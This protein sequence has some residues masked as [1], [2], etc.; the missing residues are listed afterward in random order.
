MFRTLAINDRHT[1]CIRCNYQGCVWSIEKY[2]AAFGHWVWLFEFYS[3]RHAWKLN[4]IRVYRH[5]VWCLT[6]LDYSKISDI[7]VN[8]VNIR[9]YPDFCDAFIASA[10]YDGRPMSDSELD[11]LNSDTDYVYNCVMDRLYSLGW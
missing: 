9:N 2:G 3:R 7:E 11:R 8:G 5:V 4:P 1:N 10:T 6:A